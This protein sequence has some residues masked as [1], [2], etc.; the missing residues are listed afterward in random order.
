M[1]ISMSSSALKKSRKI[2]KALEDRV[3]RAAFAKED[4]AEEDPFY[5][6]G[7]KALLLLEDKAFITEPAKDSAAAAPDIA[8]FRT[9]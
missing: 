1:R 8:F 2:S 5:T 3:S 4:A 6:T 9:D 7:A